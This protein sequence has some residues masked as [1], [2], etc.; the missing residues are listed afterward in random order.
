METLIFTRSRT[1]GQ[2][3]SSH[4]INLEVGKT[5]F[6]TVVMEICRRNDVI[7]CMDIKAI[8]MQLFGLFDIVYPKKCYAHISPSRVSAWLT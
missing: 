6:S 5:D 7:F 8:I 3:N 1:Y 4:V 2:L